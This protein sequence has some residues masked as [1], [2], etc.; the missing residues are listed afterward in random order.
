MRSKAR[1]VAMLAPI[2]LA[3]A[4]SSARFA[5]DAFA[6]CVCRCVNGSVQAI[7]SSTLDIQ[8]IC[9]PQ[10][11]PFVPPSITPIQPPSIPPIGTTSC[12]PVQV[13]NPRT[14]QYEWQR[15]CQ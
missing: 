12:A 11:C 1:R 6:G 2:Y 7:C 10:I 3:A 14:N 9:A 13:L 4:F 5:S 15:V 8:P